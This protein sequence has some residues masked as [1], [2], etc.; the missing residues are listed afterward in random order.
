MMKKFDIN[1][2]TKSRKEVEE[3]YLND[4]LGNQQ[5]YADQ[6]RFF[7]PL[8]DTAKTTTNTLAE[9][10][11]DD[12][13]SLQNIL[14]PFTE[15][16]MRAND[17]R[18]AIQDMPFYD[19]LIAESTPK[20]ERPIM[21]V[22]L[23]KELNETDLENLQD[24]SLPLPSE[25]YEDGKIDQTLKKIATENRQLGQYLRVDSKKSTTERRMYESRKKTLETYK[26]IL[27][28]VSKGSKLIGEGL[29]RK[30]LVKLKRGRGRPKGDQ[31]IIYENPSHLTRQL[32][33]NI[34]ALRAGNNGVYNTAVTILDELLRI[35][36]IS[37]E[38][39]DAIHK[40]SLETV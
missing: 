28:S 2:Y 24:L 34:A 10:I 37:K 40:A 26:D 13:Q 3:M 5:S 1:D 31:V 16:L 9:K 8:I 19:S 20:K 4:K 38:D 32:Y 29:K 17:Q 11:V 23:D 27:I 35:K 22:N 7:G 21:I 36:A 14:G 30:K 33:E 6:Q 18:E 15:Q 25:V 12:K 39:Y